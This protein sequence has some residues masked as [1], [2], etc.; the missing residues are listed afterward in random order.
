MRDGKSPAVDCCRCARSEPRK[1]RRTPYLMPAAATIAGIYRAGRSPWRCQLLH[2]RLREDRQ[3]RVVRPLNNQTKLAVPIARGS[4]YRGVACRLQRLS[5]QATICVSSSRTTYRMPVAALPSEFFRAQLLQLAHNR[6]SVHA[7]VRH[8]LRYASPYLPPRLRHIRAS[9]RLLRLLP[10]FTD[11]QPLRPRSRAASLPGRPCPSTRTETATG[12]PA[13]PFP[14]SRAGSPRVCR[15]RKDALAAGFSCAVTT[16][17]HQPAS[18]RQRFQARAVPPP[19][20]PVVLAIRAQ[21]V[22]DPPPVPGRLRRRL[23]VAPGHERHA[24]LTTHLG[25]GHSK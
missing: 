14:N 1:S 11:H 8:S 13:T 12:N 25:P 15:P 16:C 9:R 5:S 4:G 7:V 17:R 22:R 10:A 3:Q 19:A 23:P 2:H 18:R 21:D 20:R 6:S 24:P